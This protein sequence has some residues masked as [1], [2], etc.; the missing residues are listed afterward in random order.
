MFFH[1]IQLEIYMDTVTRGGDAALSEP[2]WERDFQE[3]RL[4]LAPRADSDAT[5]ADALYGFQKILRHMLDRA[6]P[7]GFQEQVWAIGRRSSGSALEPVCQITLRLRSPGSP[8]KSS[9]LATTIPFNSSVDASSPW[10]GPLSAPFAV[11]ETDMTILIGYRGVDLMRAAVILGLDQMIAGVWRD[12]AINGR[13]Q[14]M[15]QFIAEIT[16]PDGTFWV[17]MRPRMDEATSLFTETDYVKTAVGIVY[18]MVQHGFYAT[19]ITAVRP[20]DSGRRVPVGEMELSLGRP[21]TDALAFG[22]ASLI[23]IS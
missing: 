2:I 1:S 3:L 4:Q 9:S 12:V 16:G 17:T 10:S 22:N 19:T 5:W 14:P 7:A 15:E 18:Y 23:Q 20:N 8:S 6:Q 13:A 11:P 21:S